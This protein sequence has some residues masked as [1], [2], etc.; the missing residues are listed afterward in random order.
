MGINRTKIDN[1]LLKYHLKNADKTKEDVADA[2]SIKEY[3][4]KY[5][6]RNGFES[7]EIEEICE[8]LSIKRSDLDLDQTGIFYDLY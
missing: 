1:D 8:L 7:W 4:L 5:R 2:L 6:S 3:Q